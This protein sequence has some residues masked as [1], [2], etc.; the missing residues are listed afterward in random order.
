MTPDTAPSEI[1]TYT[2]GRHL[3]V[4]DRGSGPDGSV[5]DIAGAA[6]GGADAGL[7]DDSAYDDVITRSVN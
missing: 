4:S 1:K 5:E 2:H 3:Q 6:S 7:L